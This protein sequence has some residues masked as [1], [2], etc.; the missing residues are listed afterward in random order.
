[1]IGVRQVTPHGRLDETIRRFP[2]ALRA[3]T[4]LRRSDCGAVTLI[5]RMCARSSDYDREVPFNWTRGWF[6][7]VQPEAIERAGPQR[8]LL[9]VRRRNRLCRRIKAARWEIRHLSFLTIIP[10]RGQSR[11]HA[12]H[13]EPRGL[14][15]RALRAEALPSR[16]PSSTLRPTSAQS[17]LRSV[18]GSS[19]ERGRLMRAANRRKFARMLG[20]VPAPFGPPNRYSV[21]IAGPE[22]RHAGRHEL[23]TPDLTT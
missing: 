19:G 15:T 23:P 7:L 1:M 20:R 4:P 5:R 6:M 21:R 16:S 8:A 3:P 18:Y 17:P 11:G 22:Q 10:P 12:E 2:N 9:H 14:L 13:R